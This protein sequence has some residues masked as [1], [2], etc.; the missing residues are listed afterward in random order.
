[1][2]IEVRTYNLSRNSWAQDVLSDYLKKVTPYEKITFRSL[3]DEKKWL[4]GID[5]SDRLFVCDESG[6]SLS[7]IEF[8]KKL[9]HLRDHACPRLFILIGGPFGFGKEVKQRA[10]L[11]LSLSPFVM[12]QE[13]AL[14]VLME[15]IFRAY[16]IIHNHP[17]H[18]P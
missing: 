14:V 17:Y 10:D 18:N 12:N 13:V 7:S 1:M 11:T 8:S 9:E 16:T 15:Q 3:K 6:K 2:E 5:A 4:M